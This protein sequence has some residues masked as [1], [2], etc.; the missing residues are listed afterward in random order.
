MARDQTPLHTPFVTRTRSATAPTVKLVVKIEATT[1]V[2]SAMPY[3]SGFTALMTRFTP[4]AWMVVSTG[5]QPGPPLPVALKLRAP[6]G[7]G[8]SSAAPV[9]QQEQRTHRASSASSMGW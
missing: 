5:H 6:F 2:P 1:S 8:E 7:G 3:R 4:C 9:H